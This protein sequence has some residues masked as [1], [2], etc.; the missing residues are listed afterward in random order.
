LSLEEC[1]RRAYAFDA[2]N[3]DLRYARKISAEHGVAD[4]CPLSKRW[5]EMADE[6]TERRVCLGSGPEG[7][8]GGGGDVVG[9]L[10]GAGAG[11]EHDSCQELIADLVA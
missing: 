6:A 7:A 1:L 10:E 11:V 8:D 3:Y 4:N 2:W 9:Q 5:T